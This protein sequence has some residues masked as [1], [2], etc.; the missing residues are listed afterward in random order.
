MHD[1]TGHLYVHWLANRKNVA[2]H[3][4]VLLYYIESLRNMHVECI[5][6]EDIF[7]GSKR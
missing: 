5:F 7:L 1:L 6:G 3:V 4:P 2:V